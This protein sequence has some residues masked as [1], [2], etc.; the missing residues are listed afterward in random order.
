MCALRVVDVSRN[1]KR[2]WGISGKL[3]ARRDRNTIVVVA[4]K[5]VEFDLLAR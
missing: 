1:E 2:W 3:E 5:W 4:T